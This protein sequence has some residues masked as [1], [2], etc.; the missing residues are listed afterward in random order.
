MSQLRALISAAIDED[1]G[2]GDLTTDATIDGSATGRGEVLAKQDL[3]V[4]GHEAAAAVFEEVCRRVGGQVD[5]QPLIAD[6][7]SV[8][9]STVIGTVSGSLRSIVIGE[10]VALNLLMKLSGIATHTRRY[11]DAA[12]DSGLGVV[13][14]RKTTPGLRALEKYAVRCGGGRNHRHALFDGVM[15]K[16]NHITAVG[17]L[18]EAVARARGAAHHLV[19]VEVEVRTLQ[20]LDEALATSADVILLDNMDDTMLA[21]AV[22][23]ARA[24]RSVLLEAS[25]NITPE[26]IAA[27]RDLG[28]D[29]ASAGGLIHQAV[30]ADLSLKLRQVDR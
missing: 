20:E 9:A 15:V 23:K 24:A 17:S 4:C 30:W 21:A 8:S 3:V 28:L 2:H 18:T 27:I 6:A 14:T 1:L 13:D 22:A 29:Y 5:Y 7:E 12:G 10:R 26:R 11:V 25:G 19:R 16:D